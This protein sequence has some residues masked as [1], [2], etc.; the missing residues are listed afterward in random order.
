LLLLL[1][2]LLLLSLAVLGSAAQRN[3]I[4][5]GLVCTKTT[6]MRPHTFAEQPPQQEA[7]GIPSGTERRR[8]DG[9]VRSLRVDVRQ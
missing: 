1:L 8:I 4:N 9:V 7:T 5:G 6:P 3:G 2:L